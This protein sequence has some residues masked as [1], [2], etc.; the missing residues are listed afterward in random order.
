[1]SFS[2]SRI[3]SETDAM[4]DFAAACGLLA[5]SEAVVVGVEGPF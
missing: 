3:I 5:V 2:I 1:V 4:P